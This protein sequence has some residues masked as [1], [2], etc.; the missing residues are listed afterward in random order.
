M[1]A[2]PGEQDVPE[3]I[4]MLNPIGRR[5]LR[6]SNAAWPVIGWGVALLVGILLWMIAFS[7]LG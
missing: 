1:N 3:A 4:S 6:R 2:P 7:L 5:P